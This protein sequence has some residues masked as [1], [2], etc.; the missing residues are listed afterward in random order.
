MFSFPLTDGAELRPVD[1]RHADELFA[2]TQRNRAYLRRWLPWLDNVKEVADTRQNIRSSL[3]RAARNDGFRAGIWW[4]DELVGLIDFHAI[5]WM[6]R[7]TSLG[8]WLSEHAQGRGLM[9]AACRAMADHALVAL[10]LN[11]VEIRCAVENA[12]SRA[13]PERLGF[14]QEGV[15]RDGEWLYDHFVDVVVYGMLARDWPVPQQ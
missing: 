2:L 15:I 4:Q 11:R 13:I 12:R 5:N 6:D 14:R 3:E 9:T 7:R 1:I 8:W 10:E